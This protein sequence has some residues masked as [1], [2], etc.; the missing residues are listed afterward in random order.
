MS[1]RFWG[2]PS[3]G[4]GAEAA[5]GFRLGD[6]STSR[7]PHMVLIRP[8]AA[9]VCET[10]DILASASPSL[11]VAVTPGGGDLRKKKKAPNFSNPVLFEDE[12]IQPAKLIWQS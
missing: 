12:F 7:F 8:V 3:R 1:L 5:L 6:G 10:G 2:S 4:G 9:R 11:Q